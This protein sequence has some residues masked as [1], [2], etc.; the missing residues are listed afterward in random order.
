MGDHEQ[1]LPY[2]EASY[3]IAMELGL[4][5]RIVSS[6]NALALS[7]LALGDPAKALAYA[8]KALPH[9]KDEGAVMGDQDTQY[10]FVQTYLN[11]GRAKAR[12]GDP[13]GSL[14]AFGARDG[15]SYQGRSSK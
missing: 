2:V 14:Q 12:L 1:A 11:M 3:T 4:P 8:E 10:N 5:G 9:C 15:L 7:Q 6:L 13:V